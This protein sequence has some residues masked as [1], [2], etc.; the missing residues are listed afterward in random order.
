M[1]FSQDIATGWQGPTGPEGEGI[2]GPQGITGPEGD[3]GLTGPIGPTG[4]EGF[5]ETGPQGIT[6]PPGWDGETGPQGITGPPGW[7]GET[8]P[9]GAT[10]PTGPAG[11]GDQGATGP[12]GP[13]GDQGAAG[14]DGA[15]GA[16]GA[17]GPTGP[18]GDQGPTGPINFQNKSVSVTSSD[19]TYAFDFTDEGLNDYPSTDYQVSLT[20]TGADATNCWPVVSGSKA[21]TGFTIALMESKSTA[22]DASAEGSVGVDVITF[23]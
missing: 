15:T 3:Q 21:T 8:G 7:D 13:E 22:Y 4:P 1:A 16:Q 14:S 17:T 19:G 10:G 6:G 2:T 18:E 12:T 23:G 9:Q 5:G 11:T 20:T